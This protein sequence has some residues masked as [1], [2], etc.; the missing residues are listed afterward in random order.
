[1]VRSSILAFFRQ[2]TALEQELLQASHDALGSVH[3]LSRR[4]LIE[5][6]AE[7]IISPF[8]P[9]T[10]FS[11]ELAIFRADLSGQYPLTLRLFV[12]EQKAQP[13]A[14]AFGIGQRPG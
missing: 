5:Y 2:E 13:P 11:V 12:N 6:H 1:M 9:L 8:T 7:A 3:N 14:E 10:G 4:F